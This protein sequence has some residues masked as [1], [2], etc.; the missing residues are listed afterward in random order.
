MQWLTHGRRPVYR[1]EWVEL[2]MDDIEIPGDRRFEH[3]VLRF[4]RQS[5]TAIVEQDD[6]VLLI[7]RHRFITD[8]WGWEVPAGWTEPGEDP[9]H[10]VRRE[11]EEETGWRPRQVEPLTSYYAINGISDM[12]FT[13]FLAHGADLIGNPEDQTEATRVDWHPIG[14][15]SKLVTGGH[16]S[17]GPSLMA[18]SYYLGIHRA[19]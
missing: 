4:P 10:A 5:T 12:H 7:W 11:I 15:L 18:I 16:V 17:D 19:Q 1:S 2:W 6:Q 8:T 13:L 9:E 14:D 3:H